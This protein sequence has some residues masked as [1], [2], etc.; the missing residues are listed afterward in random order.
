MR[1]STSHKPFQL[2][3]FIDTYNNQVNA[4]SSFTGAWSSVKY[5]GQDRDINVS[6]HMHN[7][8]FKDVYNNKVYAYSAV[9]GKWDS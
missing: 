4:Y 1:K 6:I 2:F 9:T 5:G 7:F 3:Y 8:V